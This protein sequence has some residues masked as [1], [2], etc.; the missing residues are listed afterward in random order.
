M[1]RHVLLGGV[2]ALVV[3]AGVASSG[4]LWRHGGGSPLLDP[5]PLGQVVAFGL[6]GAVVVVA[7]WAVLSTRV[8]SWREGWVSLL[9]LI[10]L[11]AA[12]VYALSFVPPT[13]PTRPQRIVTHVLPPHAA[14]RPDRATT[15]AHP[16]GH[17]ASWW[18]VGALLVAGAALALWEL[19]RRRPLAIAAEP[20]ASPAAAEVR[21]AVQISLEEIERE[22]DPRRA[23]V[24]AYA[25]MEATLGEHGVPRRGAETSLEYMTR[26]LGALRVSRPP[27]EQLTSLFHEAKF[28]RHPVGAS[29]KADAIGALVSIRDELGDDR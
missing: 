22:P 19:R 9:V 29:M 18:W 24:K 11:V 8:S 17:T 2:L 4:T 14:N 10:G 6:L 23:V 20:E 15:S 12:F 3:L 27:V 28:S 5:R 13:R 7:A 16:F 26:S 1:P 21:A 25:R